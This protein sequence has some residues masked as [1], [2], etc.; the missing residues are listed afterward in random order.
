MSNDPLPPAH[1]A[2]AAAE[3]PAP[4]VVA[5]PAWVSGLYWGGFP[6][7]GAGAGWLLLQ[8]TDWLAAVPWGPLQGALRLL[9]A[10]PAALATTTAV[11][12]GAGAGIALAVAAAADQF[13][14][15]VSPVRITLT[16]GGTTTGFARDQVHGVFRDGKQLVLLGP[17]S[18]ELAREASDLPEAELRQAFQTHGYPWHAGGDPYCDR[19]R[20]WVPGVPGLPAG[21][22]PL[23]RARQK[24][25][26]KKDRAEATDLRAELSK[27]GVVV[28]EEQTRQYW[29]TTGAASTENAEG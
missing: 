22:E 9:E 24:A 1:G 21:A 17:G 28:R 12:L 18:E 29:R 15:A 7:L 8:G 10:A 16:R 27:L 6:I 3:E 19:Y 13:S 11:L 26:R 5:D 2:H 20:R 25:L 14:V 4:T 23:L